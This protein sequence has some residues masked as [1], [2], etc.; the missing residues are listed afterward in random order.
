MQDKKK[1]VSEKIK[2]RTNARLAAVQAT[3]AIGYGAESV[4]E[5]IMDFVKGNVGRYVIKEDAKHQEEMI[6]LEA[7]DTAYFSALVKG[8]HARKQ[9]LEKSLSAYLNE[10]W[11]FERMDATQQALL[12]C[13][14]YELTTSLDIDA[15]VI[16]KEYVDLAYAFFTKY[17]PKVINALLDQISRSIRPIEN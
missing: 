1:F 8:V 9:E 13:A 10:G 7:M 3:Y 4:D 2:M 15:K 5:V 11:L 16:I 17:E 6:A 14:V 12:L